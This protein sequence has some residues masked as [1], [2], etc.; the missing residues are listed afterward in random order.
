MT[1]DPRTLVDL[2]LR[3]A[4]EYPDMPAVSDDQRT[5]DYTQLVR[6]ARSVAGEVVARGV[7]PGQ[8]VAIHLPR[9][10][11]TVVA[12]LGVLLAGAAYLPVDDQY[13]AARRDQL[14]RAGRPALL[15]TAPGSAERQVSSAAED[16]PV[17]EW[18]GE[19]VGTLVA[20][21]VAVHPADAACV[22]FTSGS[23]GVPKGVVLEHRQMLAFAT[24]SGIPAVGAGDRVAQSA[25]ISFDTFTFELWRAIAGGAEIAV[26]PGMADLIGMDIQRQLR[27]RRITAM[28]APATALN[29]IVRYDREAFASL[30]LLCS[31]GDVLMA[32]TTRDLRAGGFTGELHN[33]YGP[34][35]GT[36][37]CSGY[38]IG[39]DGESDDPVPIGFPLARTRLHVLDESLR[40]APRGELYLAGAG[41]GRGYL[42]RPDQTAS[43]F[44][45]DPFAE[46]G[47]RM[48]RT[49][50][51]VALRE[52]GA[53]VFLGRVDSQVKISGHRIEP[54][55]I[56]RLVGSRPGVRST[57]VLTVGTAE[58]RRLVAFVVPTE[59]GLLLRDLRAA[60]AADLPS[61]L[62]PSE[63][64]VI[65]EMPMDAHGK[66]DWDRLR[67][68]HAERAAARTEYVSPRTATERTLVRYWEDLLARERV[69]AEDDFFA[70]GGHS[71][72]AVRLRMVIERDLGVSVP[73]ES[74]FENSVL[75]DQARMLD[76]YREVVSS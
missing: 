44:V 35:E 37:A 61:Y 28:L 72:L 15:I 12:V 39:R 70:L 38:P 59:D 50:D 26:L 65:E 7:R 1:Q 45:A 46:D 19:C 16:V 58:D 11:G 5:L 43:R 69:G 63:F 56:E 25:S 27:R 14:L 17:F 9:S 74:L 64:V 54:A 62:V 8:T 60:L 67:E 40:P 22:L 34:T 24:D 21:P 32:A 13:P 2:L 76:D 71:M 18:G 73:P 41:V 33:L 57:A 23:T 75:T 30:R 68:L 6:G 53:L 29:H 3:T 4:R 66:R 51:R 36:V 55:E 48:Y 42:D 47:S 31:G 10:V 20:A 52:D 49:G